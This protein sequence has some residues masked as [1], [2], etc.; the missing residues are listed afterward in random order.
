MWKMKKSLFGAWAALLLPLC[1][2]SA[3]EL[4]VTSQT[5]SAL[6]A[7]SRVDAGVTV[8]PEGM[9][10][11]KG[12]LRLPTGP[13]LTADKGM[14]DITCQVPQNWSD[15]GDRF[16]FHTQSKSHVHASLFIRNGILQAVY[17]GGK[18][19][20]SSLS[21]PGSQGWQPGSRHRVQ[22]SWRVPDDGSAYPGEV[23]FQMVVDKKQVGIVYG[24]LMDP[25]PETCEVGLRN[26][27]S[28]WQGVLQSVVFSSEPISPPTLTPGERT[29]TVHAD[30]PLGACYP[31][32]TVANCNAPQ[33]FLNPKYAERLKRSQPFI[34][35]INAVY[36]LGGRYQ[37][38]N[39]FYQGVAA[40]G[41][42]QADF[43][44]LITQLKN[45]L[46]GGFTPWIVLDNTPYPMSDPPQENTYGNTAP[47]DDEEVWGR[48]VEAAVRAMIDAF[49]RDVV[50]GWWFRVG[51]EPD[52]V[53]GH[54]SGTREQYFVHYD[55]TVAAVSRVLPE[56]IIGPGNILNPA[57]GEF[58]TTSRGKWGLDIIDHAGAGTNA[59]TGKTGTRMDWFSF[60]WY[61]RVGQPL[62]VFDSAVDAIRN[63]TQ[64]Y[65]H[66]AETPLVVGEF[67]V[68]HDERGHRLWGGDT[69]EWAASFYAALAERV[70]RYEIQQVY[71]W[72]QTTGGLLHPRTQVIAMLDR[73]SGGQRLAVD[74][75]ATSAADCGAIACRKGDDL[76]VLVY[77]HREQRRPK[78]FETVHLVI[79]DPRM[80]SGAE[81]GL[82]TSLIDAAHGTW[83]YAFAADSQAA[84][85][86]PIPGAGRYEGSVKL[87]S[88]EPG[89]AV[90]SSN[91][92]KYRKLA[93]V[94]E[95]QEQVKAGAGECRIDLDMEGHSVRLLRI[96]PVQST[97]KSKD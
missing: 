18:E 72:S 21:Y 16:L 10:F 13:W 65:P 62:T 85:V 94:T 41:K 6:P 19:Y 69:T 68:L 50:A 44:G 5:L 86:E 48:Y 4:R 75:D 46:D 89:E 34:H 77:N 60:S 47:P 56:A 15:A 28:F 53:P 25:W 93:V 54:W 11:D 79:R 67:T 66:L 32:W 9:V 70:Y 52:L 88:G 59:V 64:R 57:G 90:F 71:E 49:G 7:G 40:D 84:G 61:G 80:H 2:L 24:R 22:F 12:G 63:R 78:V 96:F 36:L 20:F 37:D 58:G 31:F 76:F 92:E 3:E 38:Q 23:E 42:I 82:A 39:T 30:Q 14:V 87:M 8:S 26:G 1:N 83:A 81:W 29:V 51:T 95:S 55:H 35:Q 33:R 17:K 43:T 27:T 45:M 91:V 97:P 74:V 73:M